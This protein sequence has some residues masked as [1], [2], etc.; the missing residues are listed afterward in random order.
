MKI[1]IY[2][3]QWCAPCNA[4]KKLLDSL[5]VDYGVV[6]MEENNLTRSQLFD[7]TGGNSIPQIVINGEC[8]G[9]FTE[10]RDLHSNGKLEEMLKE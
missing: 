3:S 4:A 6:D 2:S 9:G 1:Q 5:D 10:L 8:I 7:L